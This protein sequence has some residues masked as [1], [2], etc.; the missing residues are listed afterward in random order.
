M[1]VNVGCGPFLAPDPWINLDVHDGDGVHP[2]VIVDEVARPLAGYEDEAVERVYL[3]HVLEHTP[4]AEIP[5]F[6]ADVHRAM[7]P[8]GELCIVGPD[9][10]R[11]I[12]RWRDG[13][14]D[15]ELIEST[16]ESPW[17]YML[18]RT[19]G[20]AADAPWEHA[21]H[22]WNCYEARVV[23]VLEHLSGFH[24]VRPQ[25]ITEAA[26]GSWPLVAYTQWQCAVTARR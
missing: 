15:W 24:D 20:D 6:L 10:L 9:V 4:W 5:S 14:E 2:D 18:P 12:R 8:G 7:R 16:L 26:L 17:A 19:P 1:W 22:H 11:V 21:R 3:G 13:H 23:F 25:P